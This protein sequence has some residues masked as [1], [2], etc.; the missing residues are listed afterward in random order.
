[1]RA[2]VH[3][4]WDSAAHA[5]HSLCLQLP[6]L[7]WSPTIPQSICTLSSSTPQNTEGSPQLRNFPVLPSSL[8]HCIPSAGT[9][10]CLGCTSR[11]PHPAPGQFNIQNGIPQASRYGIVAWPCLPPAPWGNPPPEPL[12][13]PSPEIQFH[14][15]LAG[16]R[17]SGCPPDPSFPTRWPQVLCPLSFRLR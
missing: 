14:G 4:T 1:M 11:K 6:A 8:A 16:C 10:F 3:R 12:S 13:Y 7:H 5:P 15:R 2:R 17:H 9:P